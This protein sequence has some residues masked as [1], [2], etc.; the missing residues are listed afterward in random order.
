MPGI[1]KLKIFFLSAI[2]IVFIIVSTAIIVGLF[3]ASDSGLDN[4][5][6][7]EKLKKQKKYEV[8]E[9]QN[10]SL[11]SGN[12]QITIVEFAD[13]SCPACKSIYPKLRKIIFD[14]A[15]DVKIIFK[16]FPV[17]S[18]NS[19]PLALFGRCAGEQGLF[20]LMHDQLFANQGEINNEKLNQIVKQIGLEEDKFNNC[21]KNEK[22]LNGIK[23]DFVLGEKLEI[24]GTPTLFIN[25]YKLTGDIPEETLNKI[26]DELLASN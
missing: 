24:S 12:P 2:I 17:V 11:G 6:L 5:N 15:K 1:K 10:Y 14:R 7:A 20:W 8:S 18:E 9:E 26:I 25:G 4:L 22:Y 23:K 21:V 3:S 16:D 19:L 13:F